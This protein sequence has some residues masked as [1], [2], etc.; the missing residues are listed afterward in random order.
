[1]NNLLHALGTPYVNDQNDTLYSF[2]RATDPWVRPHP[3]Q[4]LAIAPPGPRIWQ[5]AGGWRCPTIRALW[6][7]P[8]V[9]ANY[10]AFLAN[11]RNPQYDHKIQYENVLNWN[12]NTQQVLQQ[13]PIL[14]C[15]YNYHHIQLDDRLRPSANPHPHYG[16][17]WH[18]AGLTS[19]LD[20]TVFPDLRR[21]QCYLAFIRNYNGPP[22]P[23]VL[24]FVPLFTCSGSDGWHNAFLPDRCALHSDYQVYH[25][26][27]LFG[28][29]KPSYKFQASWRDAAAGFRANAEYRQVLSQVTFYCTRTGR[30]QPGQQ[31]ARYGF[32]IT[33]TEVVLL[34]R[35]N[36]GQI[37][38]SE[39]FPLQV[40]PPPN[41]LSG[42]QALIYIHLLAASLDGLM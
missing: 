15:P 33:E 32:V 11:T 12:I 25:I 3:Q 24:P 36:N 27:R 22:G 16:P 30:Q 23:D 19:R 35:R 2:E 10:T 29:I 7:P 14:N 38:A 41:R 18:E 8:N 21:V 26:G 1:M 9:N 13:F 28:E 6:D 34:R 37:Y 17:Y 5:W 39:G 42:M 40:A 31:T 4:V 20:A